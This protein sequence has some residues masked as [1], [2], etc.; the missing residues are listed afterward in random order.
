MAVWKAFT[1]VGEQL[2]RCSF[3]SVHYG[4]LIPHHDDGLDHESNH[5][6]AAIFLTLSDLHSLMVNEGRYYYT[7]LR[8]GKI[9]S[10]NIHSPGS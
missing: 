8:N 1:G 4:P 2:G 7:V 6:L 3:C 10:S 9:S 5:F